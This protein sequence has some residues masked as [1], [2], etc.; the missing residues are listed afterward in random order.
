MTS[1][2]ALLLLICLTFSA[3]SIAEDAFP[4][5]PELQPD[6]DFW[7]DVFTQ[8]GNDEGVL[9]DNRSLG[10][11]YAR[12]AIPEKLS[13]RE[14]QRR[15]EKHRIEL[16]AVLKSLATGKRDNLTAEEARVLALW[17]EGVS[18]Q[19]L[20]DAVGRIRYQQGLRDRFRDGLPVSARLAPMRRR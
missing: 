1:S 17:P 15:V 19:T 2:K 11:V 8:Y 6:V 18:N 13:R 9:H 3:F 7:I 14:R 10:V 20:S 5:P 4:L 16:Q 12:L